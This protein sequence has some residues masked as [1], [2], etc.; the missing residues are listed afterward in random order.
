MARHRYG[1]FTGGITLPPEKQATLDRPIASAPAVTVLRVPLGLAEGPA[2]APV[3]TP[4]QTVRAGDRL[5]EAPAGGIDVFSPVD[6]TVGPV[7]TVH[8]EAGRVVHTAPAIRLEQLGELPSLESIPAQVDWTA[9]DE[10]ELR[11]RLA[12]SHLPR[13]HG[14]A[15]PLIDWVD[16]CR[17]RPPSLLV[18][19]GMEDQPYVTADHRLLVEFGAEI[20]AGLAL[21]GKACRAERLVIA[22]NIE[23]A[24]QYP[25]LLSGTSEFDIERVALP[26]KYPIGADHLLLKVLTRREVPI[27]GTAGDIGAAV[28]DASTCLATYRWVACND[29]LAGRVV[30][31]SGARAKAPGNLFVPYG[32]GVADLLAPAEPPYVLRGPMIGCVVDGRVVVTPGS[33]AALALDPTPHGPAVQ[34]IRCGWCR[35]HCPSRLNVAQLNDCYELAQLDRADLGGALSCIGCG[36]CSYLCPARLNL[37]QRVGEL[38]RAILDVHRSAPLLSYPRREGVS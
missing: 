29:R 6:A 26:P 18:L 19:N 23:Y 32:M 35:D 1:T 24:E 4:G 20:V 30:T 3:V 16:R 36:V 12:Q 5:A 9:M 7:E 25:E 2:A 21:L 22:V 33:D 38:K 17:A 15:E 13:Q 10:S 34:C 28:I 11:D 37:A 31:V 8:I 14:R 27:G